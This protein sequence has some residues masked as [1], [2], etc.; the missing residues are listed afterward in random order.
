MRVGYYVSVDFEGYDPENPPETIPYELLRRDILAAKPRVTRFT[1]DWNPSGSTAVPGIGQ[2]Q[3]QQ[4]FVSGTDQ[5]AQ[6]QQQHQYQHQQMGAEQEKMAHESMQQ[7][8]VM[9]VVP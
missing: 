8:Q 7:D 4:N 9:D 1:I 2:A 6:A 3:P 5:Q